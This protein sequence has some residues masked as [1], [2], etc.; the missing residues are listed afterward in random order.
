[1]LLCA[2]FIWPHSIVQALPD[3]GQELQQQQQQEFQRSLPTE[4]PEEEEPVQHEKGTTGN[5]ALIHVKDF[6][7]SGDIT[8]FSADE[9]Y[10]VVAEFIGKDLSVSELNLVVEKITTFFRDNGYMTSRAILPPQDVTEGLIN[11]E[12]QEGIFDENNGV[13]INGNDL[14]LK[15]E[16]AVN[17]FT[18]ALK[19]GSVIRRQSIERAILLLR[20]LPGVKASANLEAGSTPGSSRIVI[21]VTEGSLLNPR[22]NFEN[23]GSRL[24][25]EYQGT[26][27]LDVNGLS[28]IGDQL[29]VSYQESVGAGAH[30]YFSTRGK[31]PIGYSGFKLG[32]TFQY[33]HYEAG[34]EFKSLESKGSALQWGVDAEYPLIRQSRNNLWLKTGFEY[35]KLRDEALG[36]STNDRVLKEIHLGIVADQIDNVFGGGY[37]QGSLTAYYGDLDLT[38][39][40]SSF[41]A[42]Q[43]NIG[44]KTNGNFGKFSYQ[45][46][47]IQKATEKLNFIADVRGQFASKNLSSSE[48]IQ[49]G[50]PNGVRAY[51]AG[52]ASGGTG[53][54]FN[55]EGRY[56]A[57]K[58]T[59]IGDISL[60]AF[61]DWGRVQ[62]FKNSENLILTTPNTYSLSGYGF[63]I[64]A[65]KSENFNINLT[66]ARRIGKNP[67]R[68][69][70]TGKDSDGSLDKLR[71]WLFVNMRF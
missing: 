57:M 54:L 70:L 62:Q 65:S 45:A 16:F 37:T 14:R 42:D 23:S 19:P 24:T 58:S 43:S 15:S 29:S 20:D 1:M 55:I 38:G 34:R 71:I 63:G 33:L 28:G 46:R 69:A 56:A 40:N 3:A 68:N 47:R 32:G 22:M 30:H 10:A 67:G 60:T 25:G 44:A 49:L 5:G 31:I 9:L 18:S 13:E 4:I 6:I 27:A 51:P 59:P 52:E 36:S 50:G 64:S 35:K 21:D 11:I 53:V 7:F 12:I 48:K 8:V 61:Y 41:L 66:L 26:F 39:L 17:V 2:L